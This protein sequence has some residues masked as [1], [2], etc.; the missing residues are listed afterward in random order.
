MSEMSERSETGGTAEAARG[1]AVFDVCDTLYYSN[2]THDFIRFL[3]R[4][5]SRARKSFRFNSLNHKL[6]PLRYLLIGVSVAS[7]SDV[8]RRANVGL[9]KGLTGEELTAAAREFVAEFLEA[10]KIE[11]T[12]LM[13]RELKDK[14]FRVVLSSSSVEPVVRAVAES[15]GVDEY[16][17]AG[18]ELAGDSCSGRLADDPT[19]RKL[20]ALKGCGEIEY[21]ISDNVSDAQLL[22]AARK[23][24]AVVHDPRKRRFWQ[25]LGLELID[26]TV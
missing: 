7:G 15:L 23:G 6:S 19:G 3:H 14:G 1:I 13:V 17:A 8:F 25:D 5:G 22:K 2:T 16:Y 12:H 21:A 10:R 24:V 18:L 20:E 4:R 9:L 11:Q 26:L